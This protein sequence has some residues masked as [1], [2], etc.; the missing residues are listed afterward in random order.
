MDPNC[1]FLF[2]L[3]FHPRVASLVIKLLTSFQVETLANYNK[4]LK[5]NMNKW[6]YSSTQFE[7]VSFSFWSH[8]NWWSWAPTVFLCPHGSLPLPPWKPPGVRGPSR[9][10]GKE[11]GQERRRGDSS[12]RRVRRRTK[13]RS[14]KSN[15]LLRKRGNWRSNGIRKS[16]SRSGV[17]RRPRS[18]S[19][20]Q[21]ER[22]KLQSKYTS[23][24]GLSY[25]GGH[26]FISARLSSIHSPLQRLPVGPYHPFLHKQ[27]KGNLLH[28]TP[29]PVTL[30]LFRWLPPTLEYHPGPRCD[31]ESSHE[32]ALDPVVYLASYYSSPLSVCSSHT[33]LLFLPWKCP[34]HSSPERLH[35]FSPCACRDSPLSLSSS[36]SLV[37]AP[38]PPHL[39]HM[40]FPHTF[41]PYALPCLMLRICLWPA[42][43]L[44]CKNYM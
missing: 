37:S 43:P 31:L 22:G 30:Q 4:S 36:F 1:I 29:G 7:W 6:N 17:R 24:E 33:G 44:K 8:R 41:S 39:K 18:R 27:P 42:C 38:M 12:R 5:L 15:S 40:L 14:C 10:T 16:R 34:T 28:C 35:F 20:R 23:I 32:Q 21:R 13:E 2:V 3:I 11:P 26:C 25:S 19:A 9:Q